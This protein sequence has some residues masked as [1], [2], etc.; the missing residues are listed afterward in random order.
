M[1]SGRTAQIARASG[2]KRHA[3]LHR[4]VCEGAKH[5]QFVGGC[6]VGARLAPLV[7]ALAVRTIQ[8]FANLGNN[9]EVFCANLRRKFLNDLHLCGQT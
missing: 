1:A 4:T 2:Q 8:A 3:H 5:L 6:F 9:V 7:K